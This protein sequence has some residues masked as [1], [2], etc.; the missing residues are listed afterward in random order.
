M[1]ASIHHTRKPSK[2]EPSDGHISATKKDNKILWRNSLLLLSQINIT[3]P[4]HYP[5][6]NV[7][8][9]TF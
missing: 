4:I 3:K 6:A 1:N 7:G 9:D 8:G 2:V 5:L